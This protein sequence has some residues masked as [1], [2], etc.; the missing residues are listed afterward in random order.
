MNFPDEIASKHINSPVLPSFFTKKSF[1]KNTHIFYIQKKHVH[2]HIN[3]FGKLPT[4][5]IV[6]FL[7]SNKKPSLLSP[8]LSGVTL[9][10]YFF[11]SIF[12]LIYNIPEITYS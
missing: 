12:I 4:P 9:R 7:P 8:K 11:L 3:L 2:P 10:R 5:L 1:R 6:N